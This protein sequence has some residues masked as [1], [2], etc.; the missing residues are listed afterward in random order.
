MENN[1]LV[2]GNGYDLAH[3]LKTKYDDF[4]EYVKNKKYDKHSVNIYADEIKRIVEVEK[5]GFINYFLEYANTVPGW[6]DMEKL[7]KDIIEQFQ[8]F[9]ANYK[10]YVKDNLF[11]ENEMGF[12][13]SKILGEFGLKTEK[14]Q[15]RDGGKEFELSDYNKIYGLNTQKIIRKL[16]MELDGLVKAL[17][18]YFILETG[19]NPIDKTSQKLKQIA[20]IRPSY[21]I[22]FN[23]TTTY[24]L[25]GINED[26]V[27]PVHGMIN[28]NPNN[29]VLGFNDE[30]EEN[31]DF[32]YFKKY[33]Q[34][35]QK[36]TGYIDENRFH[37]VENQY[38]ITDVP[39]VTH[40][41][42][43]SM[44]ATDK[45]VIEKLYDLS[46]QF[47]IYY[48]NQDDYEQKV[49][50][51]ISVLGKENATDDIQQGRIKLVEISQKKI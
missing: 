42:G 15:Y 25:Y 35:I 47:I 20:D 45:D 17:E 3:G 28:S 51:L 34:R 46:K 43:H 33:F 31:L 49:I 21:V 37:V 19:L 16:R 7:I 32:V 48:L 41:Y 22:S 36:R 11:I 44:D 38:S 29:M 14:Y 18:N 6:V 1:I 30:D 4:I 50:N 39:V 8:D 23:Y 12:K 27:H 9:F 10:D 13:I 24:E 40:F 26:N 5:N 2:I